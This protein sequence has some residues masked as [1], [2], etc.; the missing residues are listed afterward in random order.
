MACVPSPENAVR[1]GGRWIGYQAQDRGHMVRPCPDQQATDLRRS[2]HPPNPS[3]LAGRPGTRAKV[4]A[5]AFG[6][7]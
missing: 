1:S 7:T 2:W 5:M 3:A 4:S 6:R